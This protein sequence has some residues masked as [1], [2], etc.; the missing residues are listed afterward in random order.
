MLRGSGNCHCFYPWGNAGL[1]LRYNNTTRHNHTLT[2]SHT[3]QS[4]NT[5]DPH[6]QFC[7]LLFRFESVFMNA[8]LFSTRCVYL[9]YNT[10]V[11]ARRCFSHELL[12]C[13][14]VVLQNVLSECWV[15]STIW[16]FQ[17]WILEWKSCSMTCNTILIHSNFQMW[18]LF[19]CNVCFMLYRRRDRPPM[20]SVS[21]QRYLLDFS[22]FYLL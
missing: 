15:S 21:K 12:F 19:S 20:C 3:Q 8:I 2:H 1:N 9:L 18:H 4:K 16:C 5:T 14:C 11:Q 13:K 10:F 17:K 7:F 22:L 6:F